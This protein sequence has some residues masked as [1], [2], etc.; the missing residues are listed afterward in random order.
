MPVR[1]YFTNKVTLKELALLFSLGGASLLTLLFTNAFNFLSVHG[2]SYWKI[3]VYSTGIILAL[4]LYQPHFIATY[5]F[6]YFRGISFLKKHWIT[7]ILL[8]I[9]LTTLIVILFFDNTFYNIFFRE[10]L[11]KFL[12]CLVIIGTIW[13][14]SAQSAAC[15]FYFSKSIFSSLLKKYLRFIFFLTGI[16]GV[17]NFVHHHQNSYT[18]FNLKIDHIYTSDLFL[19]YFFILLLIANSHLL[20]LSYRK[21]IGIKSYIPWLAYLTWYMSDTFSISYFY[22]IPLMHA[23]Q[24]VPFYLIKSSSHKKIFHHIG[25]VLIS[26]LFIY[27]IPN[28]INVTYGDRSLYIFEAILICINLHHFAMERITWIGM[29]RI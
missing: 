22:L 5:L 6:N 21:S 26:L 19:K 1:T 24:F 28:M 4:V 16:Y 7:L 25:I 2:Q 12:L 10:E 23:L 8:P 18:L 11:C 29:S 27:I 17:L 14:F 3:N 15:I 13:H 9:L 20:I